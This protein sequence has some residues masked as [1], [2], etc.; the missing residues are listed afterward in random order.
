MRALGVAVGAYLA[1]AVLVSPAVAATTGA[2]KLEFKLSKVSKGFLSKRPDIRVQ[3]VV[4]AIGADG[5]RHPLQLD[6][7]KPGLRP[8]LVTLYD[9]QVRL[10]IP[11]TL[12]HP[13]GGA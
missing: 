1:L 5:R 7:Q 8:Q 4:T 9:N 10:K 2:V 6:S 11:A 13:H 3:V 12:R